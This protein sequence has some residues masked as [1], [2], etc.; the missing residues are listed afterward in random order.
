[1]SQGSTEKRTQLQRE[2]ETADTPDED[3]LKDTLSWLSNYVQ[4]LERE[5]EIEFEIRVAHKKHIC[6]LQNFNPTQQSL[7]SL[8]PTHNHFEVLEKEQELSEFFAERCGCKLEDATNKKDTTLNRFNWPKSYTNSDS[9]RKSKRLKRGKGK[10]QED[11]TTSDQETKEGEKKE[12]IQV[13]TREELGRQEIL[14][15]QITTLKDQNRE[16]ADVA[17][18]LQKLANGQNAET[19]TAARLEAKEGTTKRVV[20]PYRWNTQHQDW[21][22]AVNKS[23]ALIA[24]AKLSEKVLAANISENM[25]LNAHILGPKEEWRKEWI[26]P[27]GDIMVSDLRPYMVRFSME[28][29]IKEHLTWKPWKVVEA[30][31]YGL[32]GGNITAERAAVAA[33]IVEAHALFGDNE[34]HLGVVLEAAARSIKLVYPKTHGSIPT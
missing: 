24:L 28:A 6:N 12:E 17:V 21:E 10:A 15:A 23:W 29:E 5:R 31:P 3:D 32:L 33:S 16:T 4:L 2:Q 14:E 25:P 20:I 26:S 19:F 7:S 1:M 9:Q 8:F 34:T 18:N 13:D 22:V 11:P 30:I 27:S